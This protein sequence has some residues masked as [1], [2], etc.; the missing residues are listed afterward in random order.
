MSVLIIK[1]LADLEIKDA[2]VNTIKLILNAPAVI[3]NTLYG[4][5][6]NPA[7]AIAQAS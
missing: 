7:I 4:M 5:G 6:V 2:S 3:V 1:N